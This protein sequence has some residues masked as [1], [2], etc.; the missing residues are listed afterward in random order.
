MKPLRVL[1]LIAFAAATLTAS[2]SQATAVTTVPTPIS[3]ILSGSGVELNVLFTGANLTATSVS[4]TSS[5]GSPTI[6][7]PTTVAV[8]QQPSDLVAFTSGKPVISR[9]DP[10][11]PGPGA[12]QPIPEARSLLLYALGF[13]AIGWTVLRS[14]P[15]RVPIRA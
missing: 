3:T 10:Y 14:R 12:S 2:R 4:V 7:I 6:L 9:L 15:Q 5:L 11:R 13:L 1:V 8:T